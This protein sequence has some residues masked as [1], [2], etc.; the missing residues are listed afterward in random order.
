MENVMILVALSL[1]GL[2]GILLYTTRP[3]SLK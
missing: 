1:M 2:M 3:Q